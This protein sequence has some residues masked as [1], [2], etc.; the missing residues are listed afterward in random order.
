MVA[1][2]FINLVPF[3]KKAICKY[4]S[5]TFYWETV[6]SD[7]TSGAKEQGI[8]SFRHNCIRQEIDI[9]VSQF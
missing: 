6:G 4:R 5:K 9:A 1:T 3:T 7:N 2:Y 8:V